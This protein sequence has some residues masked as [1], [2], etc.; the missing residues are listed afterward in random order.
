MPAP[1]P[2]KTPTPS[3]MREATRSTMT[4]ITLTFAVYPHCLEKTGSN[5]SKDVRNAIRACTVEGMGAAL[6]Q[7]QH[8]ELGERIKKTVSLDT[9]TQQ[10]LNHVSTIT[11]LSAEEV[12]RLALEA[13]HDPSRG[14]RSTHQQQDQ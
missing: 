9:D 12:A 5:L 1:T 7:R 2:R 4:R 8:V 14:L 11:G 13:F 3:A 10:R 6:V